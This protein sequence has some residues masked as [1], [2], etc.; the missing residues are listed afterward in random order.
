MPPSQQA[1]YLIRLEKSNVCI[2]MKTRFAFQQPISR[3]KRFP[4]KR[5]T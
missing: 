2:G 1:F 4:E 3:N 5:W